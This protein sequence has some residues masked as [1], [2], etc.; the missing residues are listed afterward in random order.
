MHG[1]RDTAVCEMQRLCVAQCKPGSLHCANPFGC[2]AHKAL[3]IRDWHDCCLQ[4]GDMNRDLI[5]KGVIFTELIRFMEAQSAA[6]A[7]EVVREAALPN[8]GAY[9]S[10][11]SYPSAQ[12]LAMVHAASR[13]SGQSEEELCRQFGN[14]LFSRFLI[15]FPHITSAYTTAEALLGHVGTHIHEEVCVLYPDSRPPQITARRDGTRTIMTY[16]SHRPMAAIAFG[17]I[18]GC[19]AHYGDPRSVSWSA[20]SRGRAATFI[21]SEA[22]HG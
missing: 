7:D 18:Q 8:D 5:M 10:V 22:T 21:L 16:Q 4:S 20:S 6:F 3:E 17:L 1:L 19:M 13:V 9:T 15:L 12:A 14:F 11:G 2:E